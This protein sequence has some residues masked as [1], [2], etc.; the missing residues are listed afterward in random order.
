MKKKKSEDDIHHNITHPAI[1]HSE[2][3]I[4][5][6]RALIDNFT[7]LQKVMTN[8]AGK[9]DSLSDNLAKLLQLFEISARSF[10]AKEGVTDSKDREFLDKIDK[11]LDQNKTIAKGL[12]LMEDKIR[13]RV[14]ERPMSEM[15]ERPI[16]QQFQ[17]PAGFTPSMMSTR[18][19]TMIPNSPP[20]T[21]DFKR[22]PKF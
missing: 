14:E 4:E 3:I 22:L 2:S 21:T 11:L 1:H 10:A 6:N 7:S 5:I 13:G 16:M 18:E 9:F 12:M 17:T 15:Q 19:S 20:P 8:L